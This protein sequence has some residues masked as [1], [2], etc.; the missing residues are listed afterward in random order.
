M[1]KPLPVVVDGE[2]VT[3]ACAHWA[4]FPAKGAGFPEPA[5]V[6]RARK[7][8]TEVEYQRF[9]TW[10]R[11]CGLLRMEEDKCL[12]C[13]HVRKVVFHPHSVAQLV[14]LDGKT[15][16]PVFDTHNVISSARYRRQDPKKAMLEAKQAH[17]E[18]VLRN[19]V[20]SEGNDL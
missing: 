3:Y 9:N 8:L 19:R 16:T 10:V 2:T 12:K 7:L 17:E 15:Q 20:K 6:L 18:R 4:N 14:T 5:E 1:M 13:P 11:E